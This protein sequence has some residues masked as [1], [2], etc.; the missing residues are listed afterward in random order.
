MPC[1]RVGTDAADTPLFTTCI[2]CFG[3]EGS[4]AENM[5]NSKGL[6]TPKSCYHIV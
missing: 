1:D 2:P 3:L 5:Y 4:K 6:V